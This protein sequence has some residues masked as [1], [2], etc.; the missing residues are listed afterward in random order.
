MVDSTEPGTPVF[1]PDGY[2]AREQ[3]RTA[4]HESAVAMRRDRLGVVSGEID[5]SEEELA[6][7]IRKLGFTGAA[8]RV[9]D[10][11]PLVHVAW[12]DGKIQQDERGAILGL[13]RV[14]GVEP[15]AFH[16]M[17]ALLEKP[18]S[19]EYLEESLHV[20]KDLLADNP[21]QTK[22][23]VGL[24]IMIAEA[25]GGLFDLFNPIS[26]SEREVIEKIATILG[27]D[28][29]EEFRERLGKKR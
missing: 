3:L 4:L 22:T 12:A 25:A 5:T 8:E 1:S 20:L 17:E 2:E 26:K 29:F 16:V 27:D 18:P 13:L 19:P 21:A 28:A 9:F 6:D 15:P 11:L 23:V 14:R 7:R 10:L 24:C